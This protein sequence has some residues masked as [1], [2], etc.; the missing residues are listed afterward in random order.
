VLPD[1][2]DEWRKQMHNAKLI[3]VALG[4]AVLVSAG[5]G[6]SEPPREAA[7][8]EPSRAEA[9]AAELQRK[10]ADEGANLEKRIVEL[11]QKWRETEIRIADKKVTATAGVREEVREDI[12]N[13]RQ[14]AAELQTTTAENW[15]ERHERVMESTADDIAEDVRRLTK[16]RPPAAAKEPVASAAAA[17]FESRR[18][19][20]VARLKA[21]AEAMENQ[22]K[23]VR[24]KGALATELEDTRARID[25]LQ[26]DIDRL[27]SASADDWWDIS[28]GRVRD[29]IARVDDSIGRLE[30]SKARR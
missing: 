24:A 13:V 17:P 9:A 18:D 23:N 19:Q 20:F 12:D 15:W 29:Y 27:G 5:C 16:A 25:K 14:A 30:D 21:R 26:E 28:A 8:P 6:R 11:Q 3:C 7:R 1:L 2:L 22:L 10:R 4:A